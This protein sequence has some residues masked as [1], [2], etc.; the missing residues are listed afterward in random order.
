M[1]PY[2]YLHFTAGHDLAGLESFS[3]ANDD[4][5]ARRAVCLLGKS[6]DSEQVEVWRNGEPL[7]AAKVIARA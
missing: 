3:E 2:V 7:F 6:S 5:A 4:A 1:T